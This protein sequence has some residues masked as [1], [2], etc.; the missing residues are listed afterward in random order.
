M[1]VASAAVLVFVIFAGWR[2]LGQK[3]LLTGKG[4]VAERNSTQE[5]ASAPVAAREERGSAAEAKSVGAGAAAG[6]GQSQLAAT[7]RGTEK[8]E[9]SY[10]GKGGGA[11]GAASGANRSMAAV[12]SGAPQSEV[13]A[14]E[15]DKALASA[16]SAGGQ[17]VGASSKKVGRIISGPV[18]LE[19][20]PLADADAL[21]TGTVLLNVK[22]DSAGR[23]LSAAVRH[24][25]GSAKL[26]SVAVRQMRLSRFKAAVK[27]NRSVSSS[28]EYQYRFQK[29]QAAPTEQQKP[30]TEQRPRAVQKP[31]GQQT[32]P[33]QD[34]KSQQQDSGNQS[35]PLKEKTGLRG[36]LW[37]V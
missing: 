7:G 36:F 17:P 23:V 2:M 26:D 21:D 8:I 13:A 30:Q 20:P 6:E 22:T 31:Q 37:V 9:V 18:L 19:S 24:S 5:P 12:R 34:D 3:S 11:A 4:M 33:T 29:K 16:P 28:F 14:D 1:P 15:L 25:S 35:A 10:A 27:N 32:A